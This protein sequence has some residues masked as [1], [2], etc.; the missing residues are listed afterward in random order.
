MEK[1]KV[2]VVT[3]GHGARNILTHAVETGEKV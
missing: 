1:H 2:P 3:R